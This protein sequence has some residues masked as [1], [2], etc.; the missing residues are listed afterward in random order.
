MNSERFRKLALSFPDTEEKPHF[1]RRAFKVSGKKIFATLLESEVS[2]NLR[3][4]PNDQAQFCKIG[5]HSIF[6]VPNKWGLQGW[7]TF[8]L[9][10]ISE[11]IV[12]AALE[13]AFEGSF[14]ASKKRNPK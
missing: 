11:E 6:P 13:R 3:L 14:Q 2:V 8:E 4:T 5:G 10:G 7:T 9:T 12:L 1:K